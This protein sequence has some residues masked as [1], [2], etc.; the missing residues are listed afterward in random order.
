MTQAELLDLPRWIRIFPEIKNPSLMHP[1]VPPDV[2][3]G[4]NESGGIVMNSPS[5]EERTVFRH[6]GDERRFTR[7]RLIKSRF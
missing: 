5:L 7:Q 2:A 4:L 1:H 6:Y 3:P